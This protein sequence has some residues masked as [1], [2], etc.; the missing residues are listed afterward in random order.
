VA[1]VRA[2]ERA[3]ARDLAGG[4]RS[5]HPGRRTRRWWCSTLTGRC[6]T[7]TSGRPTSTGWARRGWWR[8]PPGFDSPFDAYLARCAVNASEGYAYAASLMAGLTEDEARRSAARAWARHRD[9]VLPE[10]RALFDAARACAEV[11]IVSASNRYA[12]GAAATELG[13][14]A[15]R[16]IA[17]TNALAAD[18]LT[19]HILEPRPNGGGKVRAIEAT[20]G[21][22]PTVAVGNSLHDGEML[23]MAEL[24]VLVRAVDAEGE[25]PPWSEGLALRAERG[26]WLL[27]DCPVGRRAPAV[28]G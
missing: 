3:W 9:Y 13:L 1:G 21:R 16:V 18:V 17:M 7:A 25:P 12:I 26:R 8:R 5:D 4:R 20:V 6:G 27:L 23:D 19:E 22:R 28:R 24:G 11:W 15:E 2:G 10:V 14:G